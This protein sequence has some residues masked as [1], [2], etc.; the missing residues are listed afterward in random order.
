M[1]NEK[2]RLGLENAS[3][4]CKL[5]TIRTSCTFLL[6]HLDK[7]DEADTNDVELEDEIESEE[8]REIESASE[9]EDVDDEEDV[10]EDISETEKNDEP[11]VNENVAGME[12]NA[13]KQPGL[14]T[15]FSS[16]FFQLSRTACYSNSY[17]FVLGRDCYSKLTVHCPL[18]VTD[19]VRGQ[20]YEHISAPNGGHCLYITSNL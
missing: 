4:A 1:Y 20:I 3:E 13:E 2:L 9:S 18:L 12:K 8:E 14:V 16:I 5:S 19:N 17:M 10:G 6:Q 15:F 11:L 7:V